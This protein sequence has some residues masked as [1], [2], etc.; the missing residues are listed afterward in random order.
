MVGVVVMM[1]TINARLALLALVAV[2]LTLVVVVLIAKRSQPLFA[3][4]W[5]QTGS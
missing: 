5:M 1:F 3:R 2:P 4:Q